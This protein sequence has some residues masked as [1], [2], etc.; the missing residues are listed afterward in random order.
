MQFNLTA[1]FL[2][3]ISFSLWSQDFVYQSGHSSLQHWLLPKLPEQTQKTKDIVVLGKQLFF[4]ERLSASGLASCS[5]CHSPEKGWEDGL[6]KSVKIDGK[7]TKRH[8]Q[9]LVNGVY[10][11]VFTWNG[12]ID[13]LEKEAFA[14]LSPKATIN[15]GSTRSLDQVIDAL[16]KISD[17]A[18]QFNQLY[19][20]LGITRKTIAD[21]IATFEK[22]IVSN[23][24]P[25]DQWIKGD[26]SA[27][28]INQVAGFKLFS[29][30]AQCNLCHQ[31]PNFND[32]GFHNIGLK[33]YGDVHHLMGRKKIVPLKMLDGAFKTPTLRDIALRAPYFHDGSAVDLKSVLDHYLG[34]DLNS[35]NLSPSFN[36]TL[37]LTEQEKQQ[38]ID[39]LMALT[40]QQDAFIYPKLPM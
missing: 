36:K 35:E 1:I 12:S 4:D 19:P 20:S 8:S 37:I 21:S 29:G 5:S 11:S 9:T 25:F 28:T 30:K 6:A 27:M 22:T 34:K 16:N 14:A 38:I 31:A 18:T 7:Q 15:A 40:S 3:S 13:T 10:S 17:Y 39:F 23:N 24:S 2:L 33:S 32:G 26:T